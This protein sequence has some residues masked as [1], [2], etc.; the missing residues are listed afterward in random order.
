MLSRREGE[1]LVN[2]TDWNRPSEGQTVT[3]V[4]SID[5]KSR[6]EIR[7]LNGITG[8][9]LNARN[10]FLFKLGPK[11]EIVIQ[12]LSPLHEDVGEWGLVLSYVLDHGGTDVPGAGVGRDEGASIE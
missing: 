7:N 5:T 10:T 2:G 11:V 1:R 8:L 4:G 9:R 6:V 3:F 12:K